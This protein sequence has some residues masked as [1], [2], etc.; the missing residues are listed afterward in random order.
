MQEAVIK[1][2]PDSV[3]SRWARRTACA[4]DSFITKSR[5]PRIHDQQWQLGFTSHL[6]EEVQAWGSVIRV[7][8]LYVNDVS[9]HLKKQVRQSKRNHNQIYCWAL[10]FQIGIHSSLVVAAIRQWQR[11]KGLCWKVWLSFDTEHHRLSMTHPGPA[12]VVSQDIF[13]LSSVKIKGLCSLLLS[14]WK[15]EPW[16]S[17]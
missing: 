10:W 11:R 13:R 12:T 16:H 14:I 8:L 6:L 9:A 4:N 17:L 7:L 5:P 1:I 3:L 15:G 2:C